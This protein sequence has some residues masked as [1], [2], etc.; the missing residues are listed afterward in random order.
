MKR[1]YS[2]IFVLLLIT[3]GCSTEKNI[4]IESTRIQ[5]PS[6]AAEQ[7]TMPKTMPNAFNFMVR[8]GYGT[9]NKNEINTFQG[10]ATKDLIMN[11]TASAKIAFTKE[12]MISI[13][14]KMREINIMA[15]KELEPAVKGCERVPYSEDTWEIN[16]NGETKTFTWTDKYCELSEDAERVLELRE[17]IQS[18]VE[19]K[20][21][22][23]NLPESEGGYD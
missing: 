20:Q 15:M 9:V 17:Y 7:N 13:Y 4:K 10:T 6:K 22:Y 8:Y 23:I 1:L 2:F 14:E 3:A 11:G 21:E 16:I 19:A 5:K 12:E 18:I